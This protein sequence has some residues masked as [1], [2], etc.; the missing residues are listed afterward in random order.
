MVQGRRRLRQEGLCRCVHGERT[1]LR[2]LL[3]PARAPSA[4]LQQQGRPVQKKK[5]ARPSRLANRADGCSV[6]VSKT[7]SDSGPL[8]PIIP[9][10][11]SSSSNP[12]NPIV[13]ES[14]LF[15]Y[16]LLSDSV[17]RW[18]YTR[19]ASRTRAHQQPPPEARSAALKSKELRSTIRSSVGRGKSKPRSR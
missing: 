6:L 7:Q 18:Q 8:S 17:G 19:R 11:S 12:P 14:E 9:S 4:T 5:K 13:I 2:G 10:S 15:R 3:A 1:P 16:P